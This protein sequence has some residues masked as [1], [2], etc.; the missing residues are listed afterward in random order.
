[1][2]KFNP[3]NWSIQNEIQ[4]RVNLEAEKEYSANP[5]RPT[6]PSYQKPKVAPL[7]AGVY[8]MVRQL[9]P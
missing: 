1:M 9:L 8:N 4:K 5:T 7:T 3:Y 6:L 2:T